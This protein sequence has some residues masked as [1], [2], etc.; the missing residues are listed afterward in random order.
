M[1]GDQNI[2]GK[3]DMGQ[4]LSLD[5]KNLAIISSRESIKSRYFPV[6][7]IGLAVSREDNLI[8]E[9]W[10][11]AQKLFRKRKSKLLTP[12]EF[13]EFLKEAESRDPRFFEE[14]ASGNGVTYREE[15]LDAKFKKTPDGLFVETHYFG[16]RGIIL[17]KSDPL[18][19]ETLMKDRTSFSR[20]GPIY[21]Y[22]WIKNPT[23]EGFPKSDVEKGD[24]FYWRPMPGQIA[25]FVTGP[26]NYSGFGAGTFPSRKEDCMVA[27][28]SKLL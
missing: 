13:I 27:R 20:K 3:S 10:N 5:G 22:S 1:L 18:N 15:L 19:L 17:M 25:R 24:F 2:T 11:N 14:V 21:F 26:N 8:G 16:P 7:S 6:P 12:Y 9:S 28:E 4:K 23:P